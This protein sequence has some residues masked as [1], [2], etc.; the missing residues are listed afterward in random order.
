MGILSSFDGGSGGA[1]ASVSSNNPSIP[2]AEGRPSLFLPATMPEGR[3]C[4]AKL[5][6]VACYRGLAGPSGPSPAPAMIVST[7]AQRGPD[8][9]FSFMFGVLS[10]RCGDL[11]LFSVSLV[12]LL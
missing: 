7:A 10:I 12:S 3:Q 5:E 4:C 6:S 11:F 8:R 1:T 2:L 9:I